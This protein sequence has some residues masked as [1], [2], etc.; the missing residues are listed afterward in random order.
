MGACLLHCKRVYDL[1]AIVG[2]LGGLFGRDDRD[3]ASGGHF[4][5]VGCEDSVDF[6]PDLQLG[7]PQTGS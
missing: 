2:Q 7:C 3:D 1:A 5:R 6:F 4:T